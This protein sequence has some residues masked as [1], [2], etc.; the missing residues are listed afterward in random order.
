MKTTLRT[1]LLAAILAMLSFA[2]AVAVQ[3]GNNAGRTYGLPTTSYYKYSYTQQ[4]YTQAEIG[5]VGA[6]SKIRFF[7]MTGTVSNNTIWT[8]YLAHTTK[9]A[10]VNGTDWE[11]FANLTQVFEGDVAEMFPV[12]VNGWMEIALDTPFNYNNTDNLVVAIYQYIPE[13][14]PYSSTDW[15]N[16]AAG[17]RRGIYCYSDNLISPQ[18]DDPP[19]SGSWT[20]NLSSIQFVFPDLQAPPAPQLTEPATGVNVVNGQYLRWS[21]P[22][23]SADANAYDLYIDGNLASDNLRVPCYRLT[24]LEP[25]THT[26][27]VVARNNAGTSAPSATRTFNMNY[28]TTAGDGKA[29]FFDPFE[30]RWSYTCSLSLYTFDEIGY[31]GNITHLGWNVHTPSNRAVTYQI[32]AKHTYDAA[33]TR[34]MWDDFET[35]ATLIAQGIRVFNTPGWHQI[36]LNTPVTYTQGNLLIGV[37]VTQTTIHN[38]GPLFFQSSCTRAMHQ[39]WRDSSGPPDNSGYFPEARPNIMLRVA[40]LSPDPMLVIDPPAW[41]IGSTVINTIHTQTFNIVSAGDGP[42]NLTGISPFIDGFFR[43]TDA[44]SLPMNLN[45][46]HP[47]SFTV[48]YTPTAAGQHT[49]TFTLTDGSSTT[50]VV[51]TA[52][53]ADHTISSFP[54]LEN[55]DGEWT[56]TPAAPE[57]WTVIN[58]DNDSFG[59]RQGNYSVTPAHSSPDYAVGTGCEDDWLIS[60]PIDLSG[61]NLRVKWWDIIN[62]YDR[63]Y[64]YKVLLSTTSPHIEGFTTELADITCNNGVWTEHSLSLHEYTGQTVYL[65]FHVYSRH[66]ETNVFGIDDFALE[67]LPTAPVFTHSPNRLIF[68]AHF[69]NTP[70]E[71]DDVIV[72]NLGLGNLELP[73]TS[74]SIIGPDAG[75]FELDPDFLHHSIPTY[76]SDVVPVRYNPTAEGTHSATLRMVY[77]GENY[78]VELS[79]VGLGPHALFESF[80]GELFPPAGWAMHDGGSRTYWHRSFSHPK[81]GIA[82]AMIRYDYTAHDDWLISPRL[83]PS[84]TNHSFNFYATNWHRAGDDRFNILVSTTDAELASFTDTLATN[85]STSKLEYMFHSFDLSEYINQPIHVAIQAISAFKQQLLIDDVSGPDI[86]PEAPATPVLS[87]PADAATML[88]LHPYLVWNP[89]PGSIPTGYKLYCDTNNPPTTLVADL[90]VNNY[91]FPAPLA[92]GIT[93]YWTVTAYND[94]GSSDASPVFSFT[95]APEGMVVIGTGTNSY[96]YPFC[97]HRGYMQSASLYTA[98]QINQAAG[99]INFVGWECTSTAVIP[100]PYRIYLKNTTITEIQETTWGDFSVG[101]TLVKEGSYFFGT[102]GWHTISFDTP[103]HYAGENLIVVVQTTYGYEGHP[104]MKQFR[105]TSSPGMHGSWGSNYGDSP[106]VVCTVSDRRPNVLLGFL[107]DIGTISGNVTDADNQPLSEVRVT[108]EELQ[109]TTATAVNGYYQMRNIPP[110]NYTLSFSKRNYQTCTQT[111]TM[112]AGGEL[113]IDVNMGNVDNDENIQPALVTALNGNY[114]NPFNPETTISYSVNKPGRVKLEVYNIRGQLVKTLIDEYHASGQYKQVF[115]A[116]DNRGR[117]VASGVYLLRMTAPGYQKASKM[118]LMQ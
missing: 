118:I 64:S 30:T 44:P 101:L 38:D 79:G 4:I 59:W 40:P 21:I 105:Y 76:Q 116:R 48:K 58:A 2:Y 107:N 12:T 80:E 67:A 6:I 14:A 86:M 36:A 61:V 34:M 57:G 98:D 63:P 109:F 35:T 13:P 54:H 74:V 78:E 111:V 93:Y 42:Y 70:T 73:V 46:G 47:T 100:V 25:G 33:Q 5:S 32:Y 77:E 8:V 60:P 20:D 113:W 55:F 103:F 27:Y 65:A 95:I 3:V 110:G 92:S 50:D 97:M 49:A 108:I 7:Y 75:M 37:K 53:C 39:T 51:V 26:W 43:V 81:T 24:D 1:V 72:T 117:S 96:L 16:H 23:G 85:V 114:P 29:I 17:T 52:D 88:A 22:A 62:W 102:T 31:F 89:T 84:A 68:G 9:T 99:T 56:G 71:Y 15:G 112:A 91:S 19:I 11:P 90:T 10:F 83:L 28:G 104:N 87:Y 69:V 66:T 115:N 82:H 94:C 45:P 41:D 18:Y 106:N